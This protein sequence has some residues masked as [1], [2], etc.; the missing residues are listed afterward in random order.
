MTILLISLSVYFLLCVAATIAM[1]ITPKRVFAEFST[2]VGNDYN[3]RIGRVLAMIFV[4]IALTIFYVLA[5]VAMPVLFVLFYKKCKD[6]IMKELIRE[7]ELKRKEKEEAEEKKRMENVLGRGCSIVRN[8]SDGYIPDRCQIIY[9]ESEYDEKLNDFFRRNYA[10]IRR[11]FKE[12]YNRKYAGP[13]K[14]DYL[15]L[16]M[17]Y[18]NHRGF[19]FLYLPEFYSK[20]AI[21]ETI[22][23]IV[24]SNDSNTSNNISPKKIAE[25]FYLWFLSG[26]RIIGENKSGITEVKHGLVR[27]KKTDYSEGNDILVDTF[28]YM[29]LEYTTDEEMFAY[30]REYLEFVGFGGEILYS[31]TIPEHDEN[32]ADKEFPIE[33]Q[34]L[35]DEIRDRVAKLRNMGVNSFLIKQLFIEQPK[36]SRL[37]ITED[38]RIVLPDYNDKEIKM[39][40]LPKVVFFFFLRH[41]E[42]VRFKQLRDYKKELFAIYRRVSNRENEDKMTESINDIID[43]TKNSINEKCS[44]IR[45][46]FLR[47]FDNEIASNYFIT[48]TN[49]ESFNKSITLDRN[50]VTDEAGIMEM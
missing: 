4:A 48:T 24:P 21:Y 13:V 10:E 38:F 41:P 28:S 27:Y 16:P 30:I 36:L 14:D 33:A 25:R 49:K 44:R 39:A 35:A 5:F 8:H 18:N 6:G 1:E 34:K 31:A 20:S 11:I 46:A 17:F 7:E 26:Y 37:L 2:I 32:Y 9:V 19:D 23:Y 45:E 50:L 43:S 29:P 15:F 12:E 22:Q 47:E 42:G 40:F 3:H